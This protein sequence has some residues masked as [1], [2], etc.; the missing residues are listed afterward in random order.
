MPSRTSGWSSRIRRRV[1]QGERLSRV[2]HVSGDAAVTFERLAEHGFC[3]ETVRNP[4]RHRGAA[5]IRQCDRREVGVDQLTCCSGDHVE[6]LVGVGP[7]EQ[8]VGD[9]LQRAELG[10]ASVRFVVQAGV[11]DRDPGRGGQSEHRSSSTSVNTSAE[12]L[13]VR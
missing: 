8:R 2:E 1:D 13:S 4:N 11:L 10:F 12:V 7:T 5:R 3:V 9:V 6:D